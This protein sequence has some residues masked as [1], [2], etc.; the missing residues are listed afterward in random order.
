MS[1]KVGG[2]VPAA[3]MPYMPRL[4]GLRAVAVFAV[5]VEHFAPSSLVRSVSPGGAGVELFFVLSGYLITRLL[6]EYGDQK[7]GVAAAA[8]H[9]YWRRLLRLSPPYYLTIALTTAAGVTF[10]HENWWL[11]ALYLTNFL[12][13]FSGHW[14]TGGDHF[15]SLSTEEQFYLLWFFVV[16]ALPRRTLV[17]AILVTFAVTL[18]FRSAVYAMSWSP[19]TTVLL[20][21]NLA[22]LTTGAL[23]AYAEKAP[24]LAWLARAALDKKWLAIFGAIFAAVSLSLSYCDFPRIVLYPFA[25]SL[26]FGCVV[27]SCGTARRDRAFDWLAWAPLRHIGKISYG[28]YV[29][30]LFVREVVNHLPVVGPI[31][32]ASGWAGFVLWCIGSVVA[33]HLSWRFMEAP[34]MR[35]RDYVPWPTRGPAPAG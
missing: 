33:A 30:H 20:P 34:I 7:I 25:A 10:M 21:G 14:G 13:G 15:W 4:D 9:F 31:A 23:L 24:S 16:V 22:V 12:I 28:I 1:D 26:F 27:L 5:L 17:P 2:S 3:A 8:R 19:T 29:Y 6:F 32:R 18:V 35:H 11:H